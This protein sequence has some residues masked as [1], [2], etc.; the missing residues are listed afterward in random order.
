MRKAL[1]IGIN[2][3]SAFPPLAGCVR[4]AAA[5]AN[6]LARN[7]DGS[8]NFKTPNVLTASGSHDA[9]SRSSLRDNIV[10]L[11]QD[12]PEIALLYFAG[13]GYIDV[14][15]GFIC[16]SDSRFGYE[17]LALNEVVAFA[18]QS[19]ARNKIIILDSCHS[20]V[21]GDRSGG[22]EIAELSQGMTL[23]TASTGDQKAYE[24]G[25]GIGG[26]F[27]NLLIDAL[28]G[29]AAN[30]VGDVTPSSVYAHID[31]SLGPWGGQR[32][33]FK[34][35]VKSFVSLRRAAPPISLHELKQ[36][37][38]YFPE[39]SFRFQLD[40]SFEPE[41]SAEQMRDATLMKPN[42]ANTAIFK[43]LQNY[44]RVN[45]LRPVDAPHMWHAAMGSKSC[46]LTVLGEHYRRLV[47]GG[48]M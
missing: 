27:T 47:A 32:P 30:L 40:P 41:R 6:I 25:S 7:D 36:L 31:Q 19:K 48:L 46:E 4:D 23:L 45:L 37:A 18:R 11:F 13:H 12:D 2:Y 35:N 9:L 33:V 24:G 42:A 29:A 39:A 3:Y 17:G 38:I 21:V 5:V 1:I 20:G 10:E 26:V 28:H 43:I 34:T 44:A 16:A 22:Q 15:G 8:T 14:T